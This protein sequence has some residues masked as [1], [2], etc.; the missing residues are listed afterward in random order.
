M[1]SGKKVYI[2]SPLS[3]P[4]KMKEFY[5]M[6]MAQLLLE[7]MAEIYECRTF[8]SHAYLPLM[9]DDQIPEERDLALAIGKMI[10]DFCDA[11]L[12][13]GRRVSSGMA[14]EIQYAFEAG[15]EVLWY[16]SNEAPFQLRAVH[17]WEEVKD[18]VQIP[19]K[20]ISE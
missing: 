18:A 8:A 19:E 12:I 3:A 10:L 1:L 4:E 15:K 16:D 13:C 14:G 11:L 5:H 6:R 20:D 7:K 17:E 9:L 2:C